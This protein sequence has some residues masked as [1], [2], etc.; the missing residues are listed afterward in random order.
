MIRP[1]H[2]GVDRVPGAAGT[3]SGRKGREG[4]EKIGAGAGAVVAAGRSSKRYFA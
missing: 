2:I 4:K 1:G 3:R